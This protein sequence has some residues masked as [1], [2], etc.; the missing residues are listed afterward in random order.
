MKD[1]NSYYKSIQEGSSGL[2]RLPSQLYQPNGGKIPEAD[3]LRDYLSNRLRYLN[4]LVKEAKQSLLHA[5]KGKLRI[6]SSRNRVQYYLREN[7]KDK[8]GSYLSEK[9]SELIRQ[10]AKKDYLQ[11]ILLYGEQEQRAVIRFLSALPAISIEG[12]Y[13]SLPE[14]KASLVE[15]LNEPEDRLIRRWQDADY[16]KNPFSEELPELFSNRGEQLRS[17][18]E[19]I[20]ANLLEQY[21]IPYHY[22]FPL[23]L[24]NTGMKIIYPD[25][26]ILNVRLRQEL[27]WE[28]FGLMDDPDYAEKAVRKIGLYIRNDY[29]P[30]ENL[31][32]T[33]E[34]KAQPLDSR[35]VLSM[36][37]R[38]CI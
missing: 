19:V 27:F 23:T 32:I 21:K 34:T 4:Q 30:G 28:H 33:C 9:Q 35:I 36:I 8:N 3:W 24:E 31:I 26:K 12:I 15:P 5:P 22:E 14:Q 20:I 25:F 13:D 37:Q 6:N 2:F 29:Y 18:S 7:P 16:E 10:L 17:K 38:Y 1:F 11:K